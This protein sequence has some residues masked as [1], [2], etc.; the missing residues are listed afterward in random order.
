MQ[1]SESEWD[2]ICRQEKERGRECFLET[3]LA[4]ETK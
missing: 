1:Y 2:E 3:P 4:G